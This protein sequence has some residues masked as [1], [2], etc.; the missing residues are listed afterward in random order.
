MGINHSLWFDSSK[1]KVL[2]MA[3]DEYYQKKIS[4]VLSKIDIIVNDAIGFTTDEIFYNNL[5]LKL[6]YLT[7]VNRHL[8]KHQYMGAQ[9]I[10][11]TFS[12]QKKCQSD[13]IIFEALNVF[14]DSNTAG[15]PILVLIDSDN[16][17]ELV[18]E[19][20]RAELNKT[21]HSSLNIQFQ[22]V[23]F[24]D[25]VNEMKCGFDWLC[26]TMKPL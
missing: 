16:K 22:N 7:T 4:K 18:V 10:I 26:E 3:F 23:S 17:E 24:K 1:R 8:W 12:F 25:D 11:M 15:L 6:W 20:L 14:C 9:G 19:K 5:D 13:K 2:I 21:E